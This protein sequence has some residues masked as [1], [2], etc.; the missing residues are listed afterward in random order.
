MAVYGFASVVLGRGAGCN[1]PALRQGTPYPAAVPGGPPSPP[2]GYGR[3]RH[4]LPECGGGPT[5]SL[6]AHSIVHVRCCSTGRGFTKCSQK[7]GAPAFCLEAWPI[8]FETSTCYFA[9]N[10]KLGCQHAFGKK[11]HTQRHA[12]HVC[13]THTTITKTLT[14]THTRTC[15]HRHRCT[16]TLTDTSDQILDTLSH[17]L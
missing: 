6:R 12:H 14:Q 10:K 11:M 7:H 1:P 3:D 13:H 16:Q 15:G 8:F 2:A 17:L 9:Y 4:M 5:P